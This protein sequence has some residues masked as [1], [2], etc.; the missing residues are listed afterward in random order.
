[1]K[2][3][4]SQPKN[5]KIQVSLNG[6]YIVTGGVPLSAQI[7]GVDS[8][9]Y[10][11]GWT[12]GKKY[13]VQES[14]A[15]CRCGKSR[16]M[17]FCDGQHVSTHF[18]GDETAGN[19]PYLAAAQKFQGKRLDLTDKEILCIGARFCHRAGGIWDLVTESEKTGDRE[20]A[21]QIAA[22]CPSGRLIVWDKKGKAVEPLYVPSI[23]L[24]EDRQLNVKG[25]IW[26]RGGIPIESADGTVYEIRN[27]VTLCGCGRSEN[28]PFCDGSH[29]NK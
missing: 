9:G 2:T 15:L 4:P 16:N 8:E 11:H 22:D 10:S 25:P 21:I 18:K 28:K 13:P 19:K 12:E 29:H 27:Q 1:M 20:T 24:I 5:Y 6:P 3:N 23:G 26:V 7:I 14:Y 17:P